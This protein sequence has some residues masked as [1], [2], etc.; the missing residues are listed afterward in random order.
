MRGKRVRSLIAEPS[1]RRPIRDVQVHYYDTSEVWKI[2]SKIEFV[3]ASFV[4]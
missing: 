4:F 3:G 2:R 1:L